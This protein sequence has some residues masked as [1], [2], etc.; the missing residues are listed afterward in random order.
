MKHIAGDC[1][2]LSLMH[3]GFLAVIMKV[4]VVFE[5]KGYSLV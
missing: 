5:Q 1:V 2:H 3:G 4:S